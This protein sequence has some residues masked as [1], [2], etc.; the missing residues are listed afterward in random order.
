MEIYI[1][2][3]EIMG[4]IHLPKIVYDDFESAIISEVPKSVRFFVAT[5]VLEIQFG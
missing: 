3:I 2:F 4:Y 5:I 1:L